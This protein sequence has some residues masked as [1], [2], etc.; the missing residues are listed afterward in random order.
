MPSVMSCTVDEAAPYFPGLAA[1][2]APINQAL[3]QINFGQMAH[4]PYYEAVPGYTL[5]I[6]APLEPQGPGRPPAVGHWQLEV[7]RDDRSYRLLLQ[8]RARGPQE[9][10]ELWFPDAVAPPD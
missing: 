7:A 4:L 1:H 9:L 10:A 6:R 8:G 5:T 3:R 2:L